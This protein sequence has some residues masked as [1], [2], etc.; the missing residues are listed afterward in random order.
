MKENCGTSEQV[1]GESGVLGEWAPARAGEFDAGVRGSAGVLARTEARGKFLW[2]GQQKLYVKGVTYGAFEPDASGIEYHDRDVIDRDFAHMVESGLNC[3]RIPHTLPPLG[4]LDAAQSHGLKVMVGLSAEQYAGYLADPKDAPDVERIV[5]EKTRAIAGHPAILCYALGNE[6]PAPL[7]RWLGA[8]KVERYLERLYEAVKAED[9]QG[10][11]TY[12]NYPTTEYLELP[13]L[14][15]LAFNVYLE[16]RDRLEAYLAR[17]HTLAGDRPLLM[18]EVGLDA[19]RN[20]EDVQAEVLDWQ[21]R[22]TF[23]SGCAG[24]FVFSWTDEW[25]RAGAQVDDWAFGLT[26]QDRS[27]KAALATVS[28]A[29]AEVPFAPGREAPSVSVVVCTYDGARTLPHTLEALDT[30][31]YPEFEVIVVDDGSTDESAAI[32]RSFGARVIST[33]NAGL[34]HARNIGATAASG[35]IVAYLDDD[36]WPDPYWLQYLA[37]TYERTG[38]AAA[39]G[40]NIP[41]PAGTVAESVAHSPGGPIHVLVSDTEAEHIPGCNFSIRKDVLEEL[42]GFDPQFRATGARRRYSS[43]SGRSATTP[44]GTSAGRAT[45]TATRSRASSASAAAASTAACG[46]LRRSSRCTTVLRR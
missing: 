26:R 21:I 22:Q 8:R 43:G 15:L 14:D 19:L 32:A 6:I 41:P 31:A 27:P 36:A 38:C 46:A 42:G 40:P 39:G 35:E 18:S 24:A 3:V 29:F 28:T 30:V 1:G 23:A 5:A 44:P 25:F 20:G 10:L 9:P 17:L 2:A 45:C 16:Q 37:D 12:V 4:L 11:V 34:S 13:F 33:A 7:T